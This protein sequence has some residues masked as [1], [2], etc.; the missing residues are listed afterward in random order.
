MLGAFALPRNGGG[1]LVLA[2]L[3]LAG[4]AESKKVIL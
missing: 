1:A 3:V 4:F 2:A